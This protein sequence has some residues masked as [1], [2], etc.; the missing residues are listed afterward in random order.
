MTEE[1]ERHAPRNGLVQV[2]TGDGK[3]KTTAVLGLALRAA[4]WGMKTYIGQFMKGR[5]Y[6]ELSA[7]RALAPYIAIEQYGR[8]TFVHSKEGTP[9]DVAAAREG[10]RRIRTALVDGEYD[11]VVMDEINVALHFQLVSLVDVLE[12][13]EARPAPVEL[14]LTGRRV[15][16]E[17]VSHADL[18][19]EMREV[20]HPYRR[21]IGARQG[22][23]Y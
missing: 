22:I 8:A 4:G 18:V 6:G 19:T 1:T 11:V 5:H 13:M 16:P 2:Y 12:V 10:L 14:I 15:P 20:K 17:I 3:G 7:V 23:E 9:E 21:K